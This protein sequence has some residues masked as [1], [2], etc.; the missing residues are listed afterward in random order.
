MIDVACWAHARRKFDEACLVTGDVLAHEAM[1]W[2]R[3]LY[4]LEDRARELSPEARRS[5]REEV[6]RPILD[7]MHERLKSAAPG[8]RPKSRLAEAAWYALNRWDGLK[9]YVQDGRLA[10]DN[11]LI[12]RLLRAVAIGR[13]NWL[14]VGSPTGGETAATLLSIVQSARHN[15]VSTFPYLTDVLQRAP[16]LPAD[17]PAAWEPLLPDRWLAAHPEHKLSDREAEFQ[18]AAARRRRSRA[19]RR[20]AVAA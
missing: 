20:K 2:I 7:R 15:L 18:A 17:D 13:K 16:S 12:E 11:N 14:F 9:R 19:A 10:I 1:G 4:D 3:Q 6:S 5:L 8:L